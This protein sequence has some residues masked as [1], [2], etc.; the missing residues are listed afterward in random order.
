M[1][2]GDEGVGQLDGAR[3]GPADGEG[4]ALD[5]DLESGVGPGDDAG[6]GSGRPTQ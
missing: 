6:G 3:R 1:L 5:G 2:T 4:L